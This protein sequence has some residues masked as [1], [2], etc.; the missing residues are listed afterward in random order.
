MS[1]STLVSVPIGTV[2]AQAYDGSTAPL[3]T[4]FLVLG[5]AGMAFL[6]LGDRARGDE[7]P[8][9]AAA[10]AGGAS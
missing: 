4:G 10:G 7:E 3:F 6:L 1:I 9:A 8:H 5:L 2:V